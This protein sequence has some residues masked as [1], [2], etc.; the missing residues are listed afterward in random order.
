[1][2]IFW[3]AFVFIGTISLLALVP[4]ITVELNL[5]DAQAVREDQQKKEWDDVVD[6]QRV[7]LERVFQHLDKDNSQTVSWQE[8][9]EMLSH[10]NAL[11][12]LGFQSEVD[13]DTADPGEMA[14]KF[15]LGNLRMEFTR[16]YD[17]I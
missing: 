8:V 9:D 7:A 13:D 17:S 16:V 10:P 15:Q 12:K 6:R 14:K 1:M 4:A 2:W 11:L 5:R 3:C